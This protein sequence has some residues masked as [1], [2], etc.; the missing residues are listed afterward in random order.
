MSGTELSRQRTS[1][2]KALR[3]NSSGEDQEGV[4]IVVRVTFV[5]GTVIGDEIREIRGGGRSYRPYRT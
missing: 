4:S 2:A 1:Y 5:R 3:Q